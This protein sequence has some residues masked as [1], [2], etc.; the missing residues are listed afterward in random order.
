[1]AWPP[2]LQLISRTLFSLYNNYVYYSIKQCTATL[3]S[4]GAA[5]TATWPSNANYT[6]C[7]T[8]HTA[9]TLGYFTE[10]VK[11]EWAILHDALLQW[12][13]FKMFYSFALY[14][15]CLGSDFP[16][17]A[18]GTDRIYLGHSSVQVHMNTHVFVIEALQLLNEQWIKHHSPLNPLHTNFLPLEPCYERPTPKHVA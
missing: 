15:D 13:C 18:K 1:M 12:F 14:H 7:K 9:F 6:G 8:T 5:S 4:L 3:C 16:L 2:T 11:H 17:L 10:L